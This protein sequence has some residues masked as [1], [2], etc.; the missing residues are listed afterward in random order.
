MI[1]ENDLKNEFS[2]RLSYLA[3]TKLFAL[4]VK[5]VELNHHPE[6][7]ICLDTA[8]IVQEME[9]EAKL[10]ARRF[11]ELLKIKPTWSKRDNIQSIM[12]ATEFYILRDMFLF[13]PEDMTDDYFD[14]ILEDDNSFLKILK[15]HL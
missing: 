13:L 11:L 3:S 5:R 9:T 14:E 12:L 2:R 4:G 6:C 8:E 7:V 15:D 10:A 1:N